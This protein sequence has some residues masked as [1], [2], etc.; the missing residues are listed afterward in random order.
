MK[1][2]R[3]SKPSTFSKEQIAAAI[4][5]IWQQRDDRYSE[6]RSTLPREHAADAPAP[7]RVEMHYIGG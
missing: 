1:R 3:T 5:P 6:L 2:A 4:A 7:R